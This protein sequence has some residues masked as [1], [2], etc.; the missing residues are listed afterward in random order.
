MYNRKVPNNDS[1][2]MNNMM[3]NKHS[4]TQYSVS[5]SFVRCYLNLIY[6]K[7]WLFY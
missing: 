7:F 6:F 1:R 2:T 3:I 5:G 4:I